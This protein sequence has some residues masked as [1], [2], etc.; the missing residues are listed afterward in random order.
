MTSTDP[1]SPHYR[2]DYETNRELAIDSPHLNTHTSPE[3]HSHFSPSPSL[4]ETLVQ[5]TSLDSSMSRLG[6]QVRNK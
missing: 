5:G 2:R 3:P 6:V 4:S 1:A